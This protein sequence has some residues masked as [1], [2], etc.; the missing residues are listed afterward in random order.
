M[1]AV[2]TGARR[3]AEPSRRP[4]E[5]LLVEDD[6]VLAD[7]L[8]QALELSQ[9]FQFHV[10]HVTRL[11]EA[12]K[13][14]GERGFD[15]VILD[16]T[17]PDAE[18]LDAPLALRNAAVDVPIVVLTGVD[19]DRLA[20][21]NVRAGMQ[22]YL[23]K[24]EI[25]STLLVRAIRYAIERNRLV[26][27]LKELS[28]KDDLTDLYNRRGFF[29]MAE[30]QLKVAERMDK[31]VLL[32]YVDIDGMKSCNDLHGHALGDRLLLKVARVLKRTF[33]ESDVVAR[34]GGDEFAVLTLDAANESAEHP[35][36][37]L[38]RNLE[39]ENAADPEGACEVSFSV[40]FAMGNAAQGLDLDELVRKADEMMYVEK[41]RRKRDGVERAPARGSGPH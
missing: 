29:T 20:E 3:G 8:Q 24:N 22:D 28:L 25:S 37:R 4:V 11:A 32:F 10:Q 40:G 31:P 33:R 2:E 21:E 26:K 6:P 13:A 16:L 7:G 14:V 17:L 15:V 38:Q 23:L 34:L 9:Q 18:G 19:D 41:R 5:L 39:L 1:A 35:L 27:R 12:L 30:Q 36:A